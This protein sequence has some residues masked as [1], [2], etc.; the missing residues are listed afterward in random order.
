MSPYALQSSVPGVEYML[1]PARGREI[2]DLLQNVLS[3]S[4][5]MR[6]C[7]GVEG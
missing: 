7:V 3:S 2:S 6:K 1:L 5:L 4:V